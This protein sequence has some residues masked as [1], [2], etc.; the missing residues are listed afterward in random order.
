MPEQSLTH[1]VHSDDSVCYQGYDELLVGFNEFLP[2]GKDMC[3][4]AKRRQKYPADF[5]S[6]MNGMV[7]NAC[8]ILRRITERESF[9]S[10]PPPSPSL[11][12]DQ[13]S[14][15]PLRFLVCAEW[16]TGCT[17][18]IIKHR[19]DGDNSMPSRCQSTCTGGPRIAAATPAVLPHSMP[20][21]PAQL[22]EV[23]PSSGICPCRCK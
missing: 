14:R 1:D 2:A 8:R 16:A 6:A 18:I 22:M 13:R 9:R 11:F 12:K 10:R 5:R 20:H 7:R 21:E 4:F 17:R 15:L 19:L 3:S 23:P